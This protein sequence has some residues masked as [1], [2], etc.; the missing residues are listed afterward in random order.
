MHALLLAAALAVASGAHPASVFPPARTLTGRVIDTTGTALADVRVRVLELGRGT[1][2]DAEGQFTLAQLPS[3]TYEVAFSRIGYA[4]VVRRVT[5]ASEDVNLD[6]SMRPSAVELPEVQV[7]ASPNA[8]TALTSPQPT[9][10][11]AGDNLRVAQAPSLGETINGLAGVHSINEGPA[12]GK[13]VI[14]GL[15]SSR[16]LVL[17]NGQRIETQGWGDEHS[18]NIETADAER[19]EVIRGP[20]SVLYGSDA[21]GGVVN[22]VRRD[23]PDALDRAPFAQGQVSAAYSTNNREPGGTTRLEGA[24]GGLGFRTSLTGRTSDDFRT[25]LGPVFNTGNRAVAGDA[26]LGYR[27]GW[28]SVRADVSYRDEKPQL[29]DDAVATPLQR[30][31]DTR[32]GVSANLPIGAS[33]L[34]LITGFERNR[35]R[36][37]EAADADE[38]ASG[39]LATSYKGDARFH[40]APLGRV[41]GLVGIQTFFDDF[42]VS[43]AD[44]HLIPSNKTRSVGIYAFEQLE[45]SRWT[46]SFGGRYD[47]RHLAVAED[48]APPVGTGTAA[49]TLTYN[50]VVGNFGALFHVSEPV[51]LVLN[52]GR[53]FRAP[54]PIELFANGV[55]EGTIEYNVGNPA[56]RN[57]TSI[58]T[59]LAVR[60]QSGRVNLELGGFANFINNYIYFRPTGTFDSPSGG[61]EDPCS[62]PDNFSCFQKFQAVQGD[63][64]L[65]GVEFSAEYHPTTYLH[66]SGTAD[67]TRGQNRSTD[68]PLPLVPAFRATYAVRF[69][70][71]GNDVVLSPYVSVGGESNARQTRL[72]PNDVAPAGYTLANV[73]AGVA[74]ATGPRM[75]HVD[76]SLRNAFDKKYQSFL[77]RYKFAADPLVLDPG[78]NLTVRVSTDF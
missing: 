72:D 21:L 37:F 63:A 64:R 35:R 9:S 34:E 50:S 74:L 1:T 19:I 46:L 62:D 31:G 12:I 27:G 36:E 40:H 68:Q 6:V 65:T 43:G 49:Q 45:L 18:P 15:T 59:D 41:S 52:V 42:T 25:P 61:F 76:V 26:S 16:V 29:H 70:G 75:V 7:T 73:G 3:G 11:L 32:A 14:R 71:K 47:Y 24:T 17:D 57:E 28:G 53:G 8:T 20:A 51:A 13:P 69:E 55:H 10:V 2:T 78:R 44:Q 56:L 30:I 5:V 33:R 38:V 22:V 54:Q 67:Y 77:S 23:L 58:N 4:P 60:V 39:L 48:P 66:L